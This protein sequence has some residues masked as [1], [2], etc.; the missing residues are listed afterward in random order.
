MKMIGKILSC[1]F[2]ALAALLITV[3]ALAGTCKEHVV[4]CGIEEIIAKK[5]FSRDEAE[6]YRIKLWS[7]ASRVVA[8]VPP[9]TQARL[10]WRARGHYKIRAPKDLGGVSGWVDGKNVKGTLWLDTKTHE[11][12][13]P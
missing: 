4:L 9:G 1:S 6:G 10:L 11:R 5:G 2:A 7:A 3:P 13:S 8:T 12:C